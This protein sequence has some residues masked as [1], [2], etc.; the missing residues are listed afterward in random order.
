MNRISPRWLSLAIIMAIVIIIGITGVL[1]V[2]MSRE[3]DRICAEDC[4]FWRTVGVA[5]SVLKHKAPLLTYDDPV[6]RLL[7]G[8]NDPVSLE[9]FNQRISQAC[10]LPAD[11]VRVSGKPLRRTIEDDDKG[12]SW[13][14]IVS[15][16]LFGFRMESP[17]IVYFLLFFLSSVVFLL[18]FRGNTE[19]LLLLLLIAVAHYAL[20]LQQLDLPACMG[21][22]MARQRAFVMLGTIPSLHLALLIFKRW[23]IDRWAVAAALFQTALLMMTINTRRSALAQVIFLGSLWLVTICFDMYRIRSACSQRDVEKNPELPPGRW[24]VLTGMIRD[25]AWP[26]VVTFCALGGLFVF[27]GIQTYAMPQWRAGVGTDGHVFW[28]SVITS[29]QASP[30]FNDRLKDESSYFPEDLWRPGRIGIDG[31]T[32]VAVCGHRVKLGKSPFSGWRD[33]EVDARDLAM[34]LIKENPKAAIDLWFTKVIAFYKPSAWGGNDDFAVLGTKHG[35]FQFSFQLWIILGL[36]VIALLSAPYVSIRAIVSLAA[37]LILGGTVNLIPAMIFFPISYV[38]YDYA[39]YIVAFV[40]ASVF[41]L[42]VIFIRYAYRVFSPR[43]MRPRDGCQ[44]R[45]T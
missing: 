16:L 22:I 15:F 12:A 41:L 26:L 27:Q 30:I 39:L 2:K 34:Q 40:Y 38:M 1:A 7:Q 13:W 10:S 28:H 20:V 5:I 3:G 17:Q 18:S 14:Y 36:S 37:L 4:F 25:R 29:M 43:V 9:E 35:M 33:Y 44:N 21:A 45:M 6:A 32:Y 24:N 31:N 11:L 23:P 19:P 42:L 8:N